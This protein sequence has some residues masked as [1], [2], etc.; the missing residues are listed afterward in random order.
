[1]RVGRGAGE[2]DG[3]P[4]VL[5][6]RRAARVLDRGVDRGEDLAAALEQHLAGGRE[7]DAARRAVA[8][9]APE[10]GLEAADLLGER[11]LRDV[12][13]LRGAAEVPL[14][15]DGDEVAQLSQLHVTDDS[16]PRRTQSTHDWSC[17]SIARIGCR[18]LAPA[19]LAEMT[20]HP[21]RHV[22]H[23]SA[24]L[25][26]LQTV[27]GHGPDHAVE[28]IPFALPYRRP[29]RFASGTVS[30]A[31]NVLVRVHT[32]AGLVGQAEAQPRPYTYGETQASI[33]EAVG[34]ALNGR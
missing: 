22:E 9:G 19:R 32:D 31:D 33:V 10:L 7:L 20:E 5:A 6:A 4:A 21:R 34:G 3:E 29:P 12:Q 25:A 16:Y 17:P 1:M 23:R 28:A 24:P 15:G 26:A 30:S 11:R 13:P 27:R 18:R 14:L 2:A 8:A